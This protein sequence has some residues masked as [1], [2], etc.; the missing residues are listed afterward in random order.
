MDSILKIA[1]FTGKTAKPFFTVTK[2]QGLVQII[3]AMKYPQPSEYAAAIKSAEDKFV[4]NINLRPIFDADGDPIII[5]GDSFI[6]FKM[7]DIVTKKLYGV[8]C[9]TNSQGLQENDRINLTEEFDKVE[10]VQ[11]YYLVPISFC[12]HEL[13]VADNNGEE[14]KYPIMLMDCVE[15]EAFDES[16]VTT[17]KSK[18]W[19]QGIDDEHGVLYSKDGTILIYAYGMPQLDTYTVK[20]GTKVIADNAFLNCKIKNII[21]PQSVEAIGD[22]AF[23]DNEELETINIPQNVKNIQQVNPFNRCF[24]LKQV[25][26]DSKHFVFENNYLLSSDREV[27]Y[28]FIIQNED[29]PSKVVLPDTIKTISG[30]CFWGMKNIEIIE[31]PNGLRNI[32]HNAFR[33]CKNID[34][35]ILPNSV[36]SIES[37]AFQECENLTTIQLPNGIKSI[38][39][40]TFMECKNLTSIT[41][42]EGL[43]SI[44]LDAFYGC[45]S[46]TSINLPEGL[47]SI[48]EQVFYGCN[49]LACVNLPEGVT[50]IRDK[51]FAYCDS[52]VSI[53]FPSTLRTIIGNPFEGNVIKKIK[54]NSPYFEVVDNLLIQNKTILTALQD[55]TEYHIPEGDT[56]SAADVVRSNC[57]KKRVSK[58]QRY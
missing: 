29:C 35:I 56:V 55:L 17:V 58:K 3:T 19:S 15:R 45:E 7:E 53:T 54:N 27:L 33:G 32:K 20:P 10:K 24:A 18:I 43:I 13:I 57:K 38:E 50:S 21:L 16:V 5:E 30:G 37:G 47:T 41:L 34:N 23:A 26:I 44:G 2:F 1:T 9:Y 36:T 52:L 14:G 12:E 31:I 25:Q 22:Q 48:G 51:A 46:L 40:Y 6:V 4:S 11:S 42:P 8:K 28:S 39:P 49:S